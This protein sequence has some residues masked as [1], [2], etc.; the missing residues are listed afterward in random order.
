MLLAACGSPGVDDGSP[1]LRIWTRCR[2]R[3][4]RQSEVTSAVVVMKAGKSDMDPAFGAPGKLAVEKRG[5]GGVFENDQFF[6]V[7]DTDG[8]EMDAL[9]IFVHSGRGKATAYPKSSCSNRAVHEK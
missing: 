6:N 3:T 8:V 5:I 9:G 7:F 2:E 4:L 1:Q